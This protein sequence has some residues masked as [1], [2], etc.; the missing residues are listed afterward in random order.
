MN[1]RQAYEARMAARFAR[2]DTDPRVAVAA[3][4]CEKPHSEESPC[5]NIYAAVQTGSPFQDA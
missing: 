4:C 1:A 5:W 3:R 2:F